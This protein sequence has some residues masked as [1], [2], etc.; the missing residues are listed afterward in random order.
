METTTTNHY[1]TRVIK[2]V[3]YWNKSKH[4]DE[5]NKN[6]RNKPTLMRAFNSQQKRWKHTMEEAKSLQQVVLRKVDMQNQLNKE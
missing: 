5:W 6:P 4:T 1:K 3:W 2:S